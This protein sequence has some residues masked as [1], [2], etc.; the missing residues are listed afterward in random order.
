LRRRVAACLAGAAV[1]V[2][3]LLSLGGVV[4]GEP[5]RAGGATAF[6]S[7]LRLLVADAPAPFLLDVD[8]GSI[9]R[10]TGLPTAGE[11]G[12]NVLPVGRD[13]LLLSQRFCDGCS[14]VDDVF[15]VR[16]GSTAAIRLGR[17]LQAVPSRDGEGAWLLRRRGPA[18]CTIG[19]VGL[20]GRAQRAARPIS[21]R[22]GVIAELP[23]GLL[24]DYVGPLGSDAHNEILRPNG[25]LVRLP[26]DQAL[27]VVGNLVLTGSERR[28]PLVLHD[29]RSGA[30]FRLRWPSGPGYGLRVATGHPNGR[31]AT[32]DFGKYS[33]VDRFDVWL[34]DVV[35]RRWRHLP[36]MP[37][38]FIPKVTDLQWTPDG[39]LVI[40]SSNVLA[41]WRSGQPGLTVRRVRRPRQPA[42]QFVI[43]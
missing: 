28:T 42:V 10:I 17:A 1:A 24:L 16:H 37:A 8:R 33:P 26:Y 27:P 32:V 31:L 35:T 40:F 25:R 34:L 39:R 13:A 22:T 36:G 23:A 5:S 4:S 9:R 21:C 29:V 15:L 3:A 6:P 20:D 43:W 14:S 11:R 19:R 12:V 38:H 41:V 30:S 2:I 7:G 18:R